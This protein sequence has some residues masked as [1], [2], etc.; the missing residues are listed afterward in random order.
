MLNNINVFT[1]RHVRLFEQIEI[2]LGRKKVTYKNV[3][4]LLKANGFKHN[5]AVIASCDFMTW[6]YEKRLSELE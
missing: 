5:A 1:D 2:D 3:E 6:R 4:K